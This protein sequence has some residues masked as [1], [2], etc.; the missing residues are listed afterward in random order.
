[1]LS[2]PQAFFSTGMPAKDDSIF[3]A[4]DIFKENTAQSVVENVSDSTQSLYQ[5]PWFDS[6]DSLG[7]L[8]A[9]VPK[10]LGNLT[11]GVQTYG[12]WESFL[13][14]DSTAYDFWMF[15]GNECGLGMGL[16]LIAATV[17]SRVMF[18]PSILY[19]VSNGSS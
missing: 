13:Y 17:L 11:Q 18:A 2:R 5:L 4:A 15:L 9:A 12:I 8:M 7:A 3:A 16:G 19:S 14:L 1:M 10:D 6:S